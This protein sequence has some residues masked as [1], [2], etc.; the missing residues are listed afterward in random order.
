LVADYLPRVCRSLPPL[1]VLV[2]CSDF[3]YHTYLPFYIRFS[4]GCL[5]VSAVRYRFLWIPAVLP[6]P[7]LV[8]PAASCNTILPRLYLPFC[9]FGSATWI[10]PLAC[11]LRLCAPLG[12][13][14]ITCLPACRFG[15]P[16]S[17]TCRF[18]MRV[19]IWMLPPACHLG[20]RASAYAA[21]SLLT[22]VAVTLD[23]CA[24]LR[25]TPL[26]RRCRARARAPHATRSCRADL[27]PNMVFCY[28]FLLSLTVSYAF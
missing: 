25:I 7:L 27:P 18:W 4:N 22:S 14:W 9:R 24:R 15:L 5:C 8:L 20:F 12:F 26:L 28:R 21:L 13:C 17:L 10:S 11:C 16:R 1:A 19:S 23:R 2:L 3:F 6:L